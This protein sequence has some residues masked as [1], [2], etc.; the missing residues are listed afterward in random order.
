M[1]FNSLAYVLFLPA[2]FLL[3]HYSSGS[4]RWMVLLGASFVFYAAMKAPHLILVLLAVTAVSYFFGLWI[5]GTGDSRRKFTLFWCGIALNAAVLISLKY[6]SFIMESLNQLLGFVL[7]GVTVP[8]SPLITSI[9]VSYFV[10][11]SISY[12]IDIYL[13]TEEPERHFGFFALYMA[14]FPKLVQG[15]IER[16]GDF[17]PQ[18]RKPYEFDYQAVRSGLLL[19]LIGMFKKVVIADRLALFVSPVYADVQGSTAVQLILATYLYAVQIY[20]DFSGYTDIALGSA[21]VF[22]INLTRNFDSPYMAVS[23][24]DFWRRWHITFSR[25]ILDYIFKPLQLMLRDMRTIGTVTALM[26]AFIFSGVWHGVGWGYVV[27]GLLHGIFLSVGVVK[28]PYVKKLYR[29]L[30]VEKTQL[31]TL[32][33]RFATFNLVCFAWIFFRAGSINDAVHIVGKIAAG[34]YHETV[35]IVSDA[36]HLNL[37]PITKTLLLGQSKQFL[38]VI[39]S[40]TSVTMLQRAN[41]KIF[42]MPTA[43]RWLCYYALLVSVLFL[44]TFNSATRFIYV[45]F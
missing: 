28:Q 30:G 10:F 42:S 41:G 38:I 14:F 26:V 31:L 44:G 24:A 33:Q 20:Y 6:L 25:W 36:V 9:G 18:L 11:Q 13:E 5:D 2:V 22:N 23:V 21:Q 7:P 27:W 35:R 19:C 12:L 39:V 37:V 34:T 40:I 16:A 3:H 8:V 1:L 29:F 43:Y 17:L 15:P 45:Q 4:L 32:W